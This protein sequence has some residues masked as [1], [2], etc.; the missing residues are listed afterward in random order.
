MRTKHP[1]W[2]CY[3]CQLLLLLQSMNCCWLICGPMGTEEIMYG[4]MQWLYVLFF[5]P[6]WLLLV[7]PRAL[8][9]GVPHS[10]LTL[11]FLVTVW[12]KKWLADY[13]LLFSVDGTEWFMCVLPEP[14][15]GWRWTIQHPDH[16]TGSESW[17]VTRGT[18]RPDTDTF[19]RGKHAW[20]LWWCSV[21]LL[22]FDASSHADKTN[23]QTTFL[24]DV[25]G[26]HGWIYAVKYRLTLYS[27]TEFHL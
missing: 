6:G 18:E 13:I 1:Y 10:F 16:F 7:H 2:F 17:L 19:K 14:R 12:M 11:P 25:K 23:G 3:N 8:S 26:S 21:V 15:L 20:I 4:V 9:C 24:Y 22:S 5:P 27:P